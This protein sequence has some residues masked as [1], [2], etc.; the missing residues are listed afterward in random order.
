MGVVVPE[1]ALSMWSLQ[2][3]DKYFL[4]NHSSNI[5]S[6]GPF[7]KET[8]VCCDLFENANHEASI[9]P[10]RRCKSQSILLVSAPLKMN[11][12]YSSCGT[13]AVPPKRVSAL[14]YTMVG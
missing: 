2:K 9:R 4:C 8:E 13:V 10:A 1:K 11:R 5:T 12:K 7:R 3:V 6:P 14:T